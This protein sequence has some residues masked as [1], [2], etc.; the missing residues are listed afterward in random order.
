MVDYKKKYLKYKKKYLAIKKLKGGMETQ[1]PPSCQAIEGDNDLFYTH[2]PYPEEY[3]MPWNEDT[4]D[5]KLKN[6]DKK[7]LKR[8]IIKYLKKDYNEKI[9]DKLKVYYLKH[10]KAP[11]QLMEDY[12]MLLEKKYLQ[13]MIPIME[14]KIQKYAI[15]SFTLKDFKEVLHNFLHRKIM[16][17]VVEFLYN[18]EY[19]TQWD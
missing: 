16:L 13:E 14:E 4:S 9:I 10:P 11:H 8:D 6:R 19:N 2:E 3:W 17:N 15:K 12:R 1:S 7:L 5:E 18:Y